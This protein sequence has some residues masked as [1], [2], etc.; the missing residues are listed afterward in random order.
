MFTVDDWIRYWTS[1]GIKDNRMGNKEQ[2]IISVYGDRE[3]PTKR[4]PGKNRM[5]VADPSNAR[6][7]LLLSG[8]LGVECLDDEEISYGVTKCDDGKFSELAARDAA[9]LPKRIKD[10][11]HKELLRRANNVL[12]GSLLSAINSIA[13][14]A[15]SELGDDKDRLRAAQ[16]LLERNLGKTPDIV[17]VTQE[18]PWQVVLNSVEA[19]SREEARARR[20]GDVVDAE[21]VNNDEE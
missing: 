1:P 17:Q 18:K 5:A 3:I 12:S 2:G 19:G 6:L 14:I 20:N 10:A 7:D 13:E 11:I 15:T 9:K 8:D 4:K 16:Y 21:V